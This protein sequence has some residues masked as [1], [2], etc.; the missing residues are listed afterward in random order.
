MPS[1]I[2]TDAFL[3]PDVGLLKGTDSE[4]D[5]LQNLRGWGKRIARRRGV[6]QSLSFDSGVMGIH[7]LLVDDDPTS[8]DRVLITLNDGSI[9]FVTN[10]EIFVAFT[11]LFNGGTL[12]LQSPDNNWWNI[13][14]DSNGLINPTVIATPSSTIST[15]LNLGFNDTFGFL[16]STVIYRLAVDT[17]GIPNILTYGLA[18]GENEYTTIQAFTKTCGPVFTAQDLTRWR[19]TIDNA[20][21]LTTTSI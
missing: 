5:N 7:D 4:W 18:T 11:Y 9:V 15:D 1:N 13:T 19:L 3:T 21:S 16:S 17:Q 8:L 20:G 2:M 14:P 6:R 12:A 10:D